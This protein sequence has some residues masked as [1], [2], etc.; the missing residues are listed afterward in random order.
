MAIV[1]DSTKPTEFA[2][3]N[4][5]VFLNGG[6]FVKQVENTVEKEKLLVTSNFFFFHGVF[7]R[8]EQQTRKNS[9]CLR[10][11]S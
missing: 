1:I 7:K 3:N 5:M 4:F 6:K 8:L 10:K 2:D 11:R 9:A